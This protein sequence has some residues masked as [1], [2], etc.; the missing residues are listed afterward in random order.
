[1]DL[2]I[3]KF[4]GMGVAKNENAFFV[5]DV[6]TMEAATVPALEEKADVQRVGKIGD[7][8]EDEASK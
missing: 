7:V 5:A 6:S 2:F 3:A 8:T 4:F 1:M